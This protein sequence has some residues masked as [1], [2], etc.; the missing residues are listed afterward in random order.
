MALLD[1]WMDA[2]NAR[3]VQRWSTTFNFPSARIDSKGAAVLITLDQG[4]TLGQGANW[5]LNLAV[6]DDEICIQMMKFAL[7][8]NQFYVERW[9]PTVTARCSRP[10]P[11]GEFCTKN[12]EF[13]TNNDEICT[14]NDEFCI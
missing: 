12:D 4:I 14:E 5:D 3:D 6:N 10:W 9:T 13:C 1:R 11:P 2:W 7:K 8:M